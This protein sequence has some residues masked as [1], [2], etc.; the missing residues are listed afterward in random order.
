MMDNKEIDID[1]VKRSL[2]SINQEIESTELKLVELIQK[3]NQLKKEYT[4]EMT[5][6]ELIER[7][8]EIREPR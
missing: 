5:V 7:I 3:R 2:D 8:E 6:R 1:I 4:H